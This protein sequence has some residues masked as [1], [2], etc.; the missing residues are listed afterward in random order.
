MALKTKHLYE[1]GPFC[2][3]ASERVLLRDGQPLAL[4]PKAFDLLLILVQHSEHVVEKD[5]LMRWVWPDSF[6]EEGNLTRNIF[7]L[8]Q[9]LGE[10]PQYIETI[11]KRGYRFKASVK[12]SWEENGAA[13]AQAQSQ[14]TDEGIKAKAEADRRR[15]KRQGFSFTL[16]A[17]QH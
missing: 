10:G 5:E 15:T 6:V 8:R 12:E 14:A 11:P 9:A 16:T 1:F 17:R 3:D 13:A 7:T 4:T 2:V